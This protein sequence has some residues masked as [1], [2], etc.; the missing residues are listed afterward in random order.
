LLHFLVSLNMLFFVIQHHLELPAI[1]RA[2]EAQLV[3]F[4]YF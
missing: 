1:K 3:D 4:S 2:I